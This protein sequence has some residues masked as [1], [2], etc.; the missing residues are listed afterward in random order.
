M[1][2]VGGRGPW[3]LERG[4]DVLKSINQHVT[5]TPHYSHKRPGFNRLKWQ[6][7]KKDGSCNWKI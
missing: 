1:R 7:V 6:K 5:R 3:G 4:R 2:S